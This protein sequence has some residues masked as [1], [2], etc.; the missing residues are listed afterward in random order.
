[1]SY[2]RLEESVA[3]YGKA[4]R[5]APEHADLRAL[6]GLALTFAERPEEAVREVK[7]T[8]RLNPLGPGWYLGI[9]GHALLYA[10]RYDEAL[11]TLSE[12]NRRSP[13][14][15]LVDVVLT[16]TETRDIERRGDTRRSFSQP[17]P[18]S[19]LKNGP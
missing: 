9:L 18:N 5:L 4:A 2:L 16:Y 7:A 14:F 17:V 19:R 6:S 8:I 12:Y 13:G 15:G 11:E 1:M 3:A 10:G